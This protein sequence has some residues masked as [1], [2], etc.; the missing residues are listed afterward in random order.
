MQVDGSVFPLSANQEGVWIA[1]ALDNSAAYNFSALLKLNPGFSAEDA[2][3]AL[4]RVT[5]RVEP[6]RYGFEESG[7][8]VWQF[9]RGMDP[10]STHIEFGQRRQL[11]RFFRRRYDL[12][13]GEPPIRWLVFE[14][15]VGAVYIAH[16]EHH[17]I[18]DGRS[19]NLF[20]EELSD[21]LFDRQPVDRGRSY[22][23]YIDFAL[24]Q[25]ST[26]SYVHARE[27]SL[28]EA[29]ETTA[30]KPLHGYT[31]GA[32]GQGSSI[33]VRLRHAQFTAVADCA[34]R[35]RVS[36]FS[37][38]V[39]ALTDVL[40]KYRDEDDGVCLGL[41]FEN[42]PEEWMQT[43]GLFVNVVPIALSN[44]RLAMSAD[45]VRYSFDSILAAAR[46][47]AVSLS[48]VVRG[49]RW[50]RRRS[51]HPLI[52]AG[53]SWQQARPNCP[54]RDG[55]RIL[56][57]GIFNGRAKFDVSVILV[58]SPDWRRWDDE[59]YSLHAI[60]ESSSA[61]SASELLSISNSWRRCLEA[62]GSLDA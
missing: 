51:T 25:R 61:F 16:S 55:V 8:R 58:G 35:L 31:N 4:S 19:F 5:A 49:I 45:N 27:I 46:R 15:A 30:W 44:D 2:V 38:F 37:I 50:R 60:W 1:S 20:I 11:T 42:R 34:R 53:I 22:R 52:H 41:G 21:A 43:V 54:T 14:D 59:A 3:R 33:L 10:L 48:E 29:A 36:P 12:T 18:H 23:E 32:S 9:T 40:S 26:A 6:F 47:Q 17:V 62:T 7:G 39:T 56:R 13:G 57:Q 24:R 28:A